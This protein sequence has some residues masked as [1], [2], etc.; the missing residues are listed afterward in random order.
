M[1]YATLWLRTQLQW[2]AEIERKKA[3][4]VDLYAEP[5]LTQVQSTTVKIESPKIE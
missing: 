2:Q 1:L 4:V 5:M 3:L